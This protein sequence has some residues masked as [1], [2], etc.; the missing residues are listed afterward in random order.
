[1]RVCRRRGDNSAPAYQAA[2]DSPFPLV[3]PKQLHSSHAPVDRRG[4]LNCAGGG[5]S[6]RRRARPRIVFVHGS[7]MGGRPTWSGQ[8]G[9]RRPLQSR[10]AGAARISAESTR[11]PRRLRG[12]CRSRG[13]TLSA[14]ALT[15][16]V[17]PTAASSRYSRLRWFR[18]P[19]RSLTVIEPPATRVAEGNPAVDAFVRRR[20]RVVGDGADRRP[21]GIPARI[22]GHGRFRLRSPFPAPVSARAGSA[23]PD[24][25]ARAVGGRDPPGCPGRGAVPDPRRLGRP[26]SRRSTPS[27]TSSPSGLGADTWSAGLRAHR[28]AAS[29]FQREADGVH[30]QRCRFRSGTCPASYALRRSSPSCSA[31]RRRTRGFPSFTISSR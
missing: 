30:R 24:R 20:D 22:P 27:A 31:S 17:T 29:G 3:E 15:S 6:G 14:A 19:L 16:S 11:R 5:G 2:C 9:A 13:R 26:P 7:V 10:D 21:R 8:R 1:M 28:A 18:P 25:R 23:D 4:G 12:A